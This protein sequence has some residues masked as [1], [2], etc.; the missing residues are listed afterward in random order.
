M[1]CYCRSRNG[2]PKEHYRSVDHAAGVAAGRG[3]VVDV[4]PCPTESRVFHVTHLKEKSSPEVNAG[5]RPG[6][7]RSV[8]RFGEK[9]LRKE[10]IR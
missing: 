2:Q 6:R 5:R 8:E 4:Y 9:L 10:G 3:W 1:T 7:L